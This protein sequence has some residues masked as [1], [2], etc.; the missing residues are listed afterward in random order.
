M[1]EEVKA[2]HTLG[3]AGKWHKWDTEMGYPR[4]GK[5]IREEWFVSGRGECAYIYWE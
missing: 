4:S 2:L 3:G 1:L 5:W